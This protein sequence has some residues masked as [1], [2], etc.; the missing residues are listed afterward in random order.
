[1][2]H[3][4]PAERRPV[5]GLGL[6]SAPRTL[7]T[8]TQILNVVYVIRDVDL[9]T[10]SWIKTNVDLCVQPRWYNTSLL[11]TEWVFHDV[12]VSALDGKC[13]IAVWI[14]FFFTLDDLFVYVRY[15]TLNCLNS[16]NELILMIHVQLF[17]F[18]ISIKYVHCLGQSNQSN[19]SQ[20]NYKILYIFIWF[21][22]HAFA[23][24]V[25]TLIGKSVV[26]KSSPCCVSGCIL[27]FFR[28][29]NKRFLKITVKL[30]LIREIEAHL[31]LVHF[32]SINSD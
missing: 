21:G 11:V 20:A 14:L 19:S 1:M 10:K 23:V 5:D 3:V 31:Y 6:S 2:P 13:T 16:Y 17:T 7:W 12:V 32:Q 29:A 30:W 18:I 4:F 26:R 15:P 25:F 8:Q 22:L 24:S 28:Q 9:F 27:H